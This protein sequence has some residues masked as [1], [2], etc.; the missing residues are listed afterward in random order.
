MNTNL[1]TALTAD[2]LL[3]IEGGNFAYDAGRVIRFIVISGGG[4]IAG[5]AIADW[6]STAAMMEA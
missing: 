2:E 5:Q 3:G 1:A 6:I 4:E